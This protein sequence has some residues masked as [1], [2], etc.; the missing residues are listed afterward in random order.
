MNANEQFYSQPSY[1]STVK[2]YSK[3]NS[4][5]GGNYFWNTN[6]KSSVKDELHKLSKENATAK[7]QLSYRDTWIG[8]DSPF[9]PDKK[10]L[11]ATIQRNDK[12]MKKLV[13]E[14]NRNYK[15]NHTNFISYY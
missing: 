2:T 9:L 15:R 8:E 5:R 7:F 10:T 1:L 14:H 11:R 6:V 4:Q 3:K 13:D 12:R